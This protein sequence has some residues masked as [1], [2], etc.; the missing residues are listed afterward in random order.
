MM[1]AMHHARRPTKH[2][3][4]QL[5]HHHH[6]RHASTQPNNF[7]LVQVQTHHNMPSL[8]STANLPA[9]ATLFQFTGALLTENTGDRCLQVGHARWITPRP[10]E[11][12]PPWV[13]LN[14]SFQPS[15]RI[16]HP[17][18]GEDDTTIGNEESFVVTAT[19]TVD[20]AKDTPLTIDY[21][22]H[23]HLMFG[24]GFECAESGRSV[25]GWLHLTDEEKQDSLPHAMKHIQLLHN[26]DTK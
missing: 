16:S 2:I 7:S 20:V 5:L 3:L 13:F 22:L 15:V 26:E 12:E 18:L 1:N 19:A 10:N 14:H 6:H 23:E 21:T 24:Q 8:L 17:F 4:H 11:H 25:R 9:G